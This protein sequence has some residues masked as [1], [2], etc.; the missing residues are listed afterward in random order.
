MRERKLFIYLFNPHIK[1]I[2]LFLK[3]SQIKKKKNPFAVNSAT[4][5]ASQVKV[6]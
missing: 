3:M 4:M 5:M 6:N 1:S 2:T